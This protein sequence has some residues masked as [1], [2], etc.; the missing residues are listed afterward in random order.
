[1]YNIKVQYPKTLIQVKNTII[2][3]WMFFLHMGHWWRRCAHFSQVTRCLQGRNKTCTSS[4]KQTLHLTSWAWF[5]KSMDSFC[6]RFWSRFSS[7][8]RLLCLSA[9][10]S[11]FSFW[12]SSLACCRACC[13]CLSLSSY[14][15]WDFTNCWVFFFIFWRV[16][17]R[18]RVLSATSSSSCTNIIVLNL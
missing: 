17:F 13:C 2:V 15:C 10:S 18:A 14:L 8:S 16:F 7:S 12:I 11:P 4:T 3:S 1:M 5:N 6:C 9:C